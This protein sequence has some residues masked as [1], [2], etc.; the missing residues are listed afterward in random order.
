METS[1]TRTATE[2]Q[3]ANTTTNLIKELYHVNYLVAYPIS[4]SM[5]EGWAKCLTELAPG[6]S[7]Y[8]LKDII[9]KMKM[10]HIA[11]DHKKGIQNIF[12]AY[13]KMNKINTYTD[14][15]L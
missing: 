13:Q 3:L 15:L 1:L 12:I 7:S 2:N 5:L 6:M 10:G 8:L 11:Y 4:D 9:D 14:G